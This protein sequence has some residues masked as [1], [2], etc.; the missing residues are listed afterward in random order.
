MRSVADWRRF[1]WQSYSKSHARRSSWVSSLRRSPVLY[2][3]TLRHLR[4]EQL[5]A[6]LRRR[7]ASPRPDLRAAPVLRARPGRFIEPCAPAAT[8]AATGFRALGVERAIDDATIWNDERQPALWL[9][10]LHYFDDLNAVD[11]A[12]RRAS[13]EKLLQRWIRENPPPAGIGWQPYPVARR[14]VN[15]IKWALRGGDAECLRH[16]LAVQ[17]RWLAGNLEFHLGGNHLLADAKALLFAGLFFSGAEA[18]RWRERGARL[19]DRELADQVLPDGGHV[20]R[21]PMYHAATLEDLLDVLNLLAAYGQPL[22]PKW[23]DAAARMARWLAALTHPDGEP[24][25]FNDTAFGIAPTHDELESY[26][27]RLGMAM[28]QSLPDFAVLADSGYVRAR[29]GPAWLACDCAPLGPDH[30][31]AHGHADSLSFELSLDA[32]R[33]LVNSGTSLYGESAERL[34]QRGTAAH[35]TVV[36]DGLD[37]S[38]VWSGFRVARRARVRLLEARDTESALIDASHDGY[39]RLPG[40][41]LHRRRWQLDARSLLVEDHVSGTFQSARAHLHLHPEVRVERTGPTCFALRTPEDRALRLDFTGAREVELRA[42]TWHPR[43]GESRANATVVAT[44]GGGRLAAR[45]SWN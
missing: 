4:F 3:H 36:L 6:Q 11:S 1:P 34:R 9:Y 10:N 24:A 28:T 21:S 8:L 5:A 27:R 18:G 38:E 35:N 12:M 32:H 42:G 14:L 16:S 7:L 19:F 43:F 15:W 13:H 37:S 45:L 33:V 29:R 40:R 2:F 41:N 22:P 30:L 25:F 23:L 26:G 17:V 39:R 44:L 20:E 31:P